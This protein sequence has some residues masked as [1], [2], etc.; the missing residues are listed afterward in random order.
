MPD[1]RVR[2]TGLLTEDEL[3][4]PQP[5]PEGP[6]I[7]LGGITAVGTWIHTWFRSRPGQA[8]VNAHPEVRRQLL[9]AGVTILFRDPSTAG[10]TPDERADLL[11]DPG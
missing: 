1:E 9:D 5:L 7:D 8:V 6:V 10:I 11:G 2:W 3:L 4:W